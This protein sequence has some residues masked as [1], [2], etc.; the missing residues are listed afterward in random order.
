M[1]YEVPLDDKFLSDAYDRQSAD[2]NKMEKIQKF[3][4]WRA[5]QQMAL[6]WKRTRPDPVTGEM[7]EDQAA[8]IDL[9]KLCVADLRGSP[10]EKATK[11]VDSLVQSTLA[12]MVKAGE[13]VFEETMRLAFETLA[14]L[15][16]TPSDL[17]HEYGIAIGE[18]E[19]CLR[20]TIELGGRKHPDAD[21]TD[22]EKMLSAPAKK[23]G[24]AVAMAMG[25]ENIFWA[26]K[27]KAY[28]ERQTVLASM[29]PKI[30]TVLREVRQAGV[31]IGPSVLK[32]HLAKYKEVMDCSD[33]CDMDV[34]RE[35]MKKNA[36]TL[37]ASAQKDFRNGAGKGRDWNLHIQ[38]F[39]ESASIFKD[40]K[41]T[42]WI[43][44]AKRMQ[45]TDFA[46][47]KLKDLSAACAECH[48]AI[49][50][51]SLDKVN[52]CLKK[53]AG[54][55]K[56]LPHDERNAETYAT[57]A[58]FAV[59]LFNDAV[60]L[61]ATDANFSESNALRASLALNPLVAKRCRSVSSSTRLVT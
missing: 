54:L 16:E 27:K 13:A 10:K 37:L 12:P 22:V 58:D 14:V 8:P 52:E 23:A 25:D 7:Q 29:A 4:E 39:Q 34:L 47:T 60:L 51:E 24:G 59:Y 2:W 30:K 49:S 42:Q 61:F 43:R 19:Q 28:M 57:V 50:N 38:V 32:E 18:V 33:C 31:M 48:A 56:Y 5:M 40:P 17:P 21:H 55:E 46:V 45:A 11:F 36:D 41:L 35:V 20:A 15:K 6:L 3:T 53:A 44:D 9:T 26:E 1:R